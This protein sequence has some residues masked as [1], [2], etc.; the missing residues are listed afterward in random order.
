MATYWYKNTLRNYGIHVKRS[1]L[2]PCLCWTSCAQIVELSVGWCTTKKSGPV[3]CN[4]FS[5]YSSVQSY[6]NDLKL[7]PLKDHRR[8]IRLT[9]I[10]KIVT[11]RL[12]VW[13]EGTLL[14]ADSCTWHKHM[15]KYRHL[16]ATCSR[17]LNSFFVKTIPDWNSSPEACFTADTVTAFQA[18]QPCPP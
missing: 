5:R 17:C 1:R 11:G 8:D 15:H 2:S 14:P 9:F 16:P 4:D 6:L 7:A 3:C 12:A 10:F 18:C 13:A